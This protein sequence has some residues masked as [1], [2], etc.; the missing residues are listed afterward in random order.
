[1]NPIDWT[2]PNAQVTEHFTVKDLCFLHAWGRLA[3]EAD[4]A[5]FAKLE[6]LAQKAEQVRSMLGVP[7]NVHCGFRS[8]QYNIDQ[9]ILL[10]TGKDVHQMCLAVD[11]DALP[12]LSIAATK[13]ALLPHLEALGIRIEYGTTTWVHF[14]LHAP[15][16]SGRYFHV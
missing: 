12:S 14:D 9:G 4:G 3:T 6:V 2:N 8:A 13:F 10:P 16:P 5:D 11:F 1:M 7:M 15:G